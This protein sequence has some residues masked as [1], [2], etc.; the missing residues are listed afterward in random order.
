MRERR[1]YRRIVINAN[2]L[3]FVED[4]AAEI[5]GRVKDISEES[6]GL[7]F[8]INDA[9][10][11]ALDDKGM[12]RFQFVDTYRD[13]R[14]ERT[15]VVQACALIKRIKVTENTCLIGCMVRDD[16]FKKYVVKR[17]LSAYFT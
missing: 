1:N 13:G 17:K 5:C 2:V 7:E 16:S 14:R 3:V 15:E 9:L 4:Y 12:V 10:K 8:E 6:I 11:K